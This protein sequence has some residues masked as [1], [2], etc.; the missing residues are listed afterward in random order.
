MQP[1]GTFCWPVKVFTA[2]DGKG[3]TAKVWATQLQLIRG[4]G[5]IGL[6]SEA[7]AMARRWAAERAAS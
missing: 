5:P 1:S 4:S 3:R 6:L 7:I 2:T